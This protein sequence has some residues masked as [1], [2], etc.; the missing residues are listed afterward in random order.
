MITLCLCCSM[1]MTVGTELGFIPD[2]ASTSTVEYETA[3]VAKLATATVLALT[4][5]ST[6]SQTPLPPMK[7]E[8]RYVT[9]AVANLRACPS[10]DCEIL[11][12]MNYG[13]LFRATEQKSDSDG[14]VWYALEHDDKTAWIAGWLTSANPPSARPQPTPASQTDPQQAVP[15]QPTQAEQPAQPV[16]G[17]TC[18]CSKLCGAMVSC[19]EAYF[20]LNQCGCRARDA[21]YDG[22]PCE[23]LC[24]GG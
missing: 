9:A 16:T 6:P 4:P 21:D 19:E 7:P 2:Y 22:V 13:E 11:G 1:G 24:P 18:N 5:S 20:Q 14:S 15:Q 8:D 12:Q 3:Q 23:G 17:F 10:I